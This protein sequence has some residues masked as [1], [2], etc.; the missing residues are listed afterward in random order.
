[1]V[2]RRRP[3]MRHQAGDRGHLASVCT[4]NDMGRSIRAELEPESGRLAR[5]A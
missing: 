4:V 2:F 5:A 1:M 3:I